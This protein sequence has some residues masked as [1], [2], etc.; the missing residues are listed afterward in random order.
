MVSIE[1]KYQGN[2]T[3][4]EATVIINGKERKHSNISKTP[5]EYA[6]LCDKNGWEIT[7]LTLIKP[8]SNKPSA[9]AGLP[10][11]WKR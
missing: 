11:S 5:K 4:V 1:T 3:K 8:E 2:Q 9:D 10:N 7:S 6:D